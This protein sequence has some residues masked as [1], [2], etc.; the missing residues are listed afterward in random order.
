[1]VPSATGAGERGKEARVEW[2]GNG[3]FGAVIWDFEWG[4]GLR[5]K[6]GLGRVGEGL[7]G[8]RR[9]GWGWREGDPG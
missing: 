2:E 9:G 8:Y 5:L 6:L 7:G 3:C 1:M 4:R